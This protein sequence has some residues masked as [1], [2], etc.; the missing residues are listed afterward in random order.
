MKIFFITNL[1]TF[2]SKVLLT[3]KSMD[4]ENV[5]WTKSCSCLCDKRHSMHNEF[6][7]KMYL[8]LKF[9]VKRGTQ[10]RKIIN[11]KLT[12]KQHVMCNL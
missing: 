9:N 8:Y 4:F 11:Y 6:V 1:N 2:G 12:Q 7:I 5:P 3:L 10:N